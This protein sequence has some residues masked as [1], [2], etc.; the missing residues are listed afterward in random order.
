MQASLTLDGSDPGPLFGPAHLKRLS[1]A[2]QRSRIYRDKCKKATPPWA[3]KNQIRKLYKEARRLTAV[4]GT[5][6]TVD[7]IVPLKGE[8]VCGLHV[9][10]NLEVTTQ[11]ENLKKGNKFVEQPGLFDG[12]H[13]PL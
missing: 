12:L 4:T 8:R 2:K 1:K 13:L 9:H 10:Y 6:H 3:V 7:H 11:K 5:P